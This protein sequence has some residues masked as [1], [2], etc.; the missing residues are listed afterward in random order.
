[1]YVAVTGIYLPISLISIGKK[2]PE[3]RIVLR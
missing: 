2:F 3:K 1:V